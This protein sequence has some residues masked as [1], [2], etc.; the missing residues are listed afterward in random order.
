MGGRRIQIPV[1]EC[2]A[3][4][5]L[6]VLDLELLQAGL[7]VSQASGQP[8]EAPGRPGSEAAAGDPQRQGEAAAELNDLVGGLTLGIHT[9]GSCQLCQEVHGVMGIH[10]V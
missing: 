5:H 4:P 9:L 6:Q 3:C 7:L 2:K 8:G 1:T 10:H